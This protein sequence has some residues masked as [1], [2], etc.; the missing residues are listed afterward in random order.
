MLDDNIRSFT[1]QSVYNQHG[2]SKSHNDLYGQDDDVFQMQKDEPYYRDNPHFS[3][4]KSNTNI[5]Y[6]NYR[7]MERSDADGWD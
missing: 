5:D 6:Y 3:A 2:F 7:N 1:N 4:S